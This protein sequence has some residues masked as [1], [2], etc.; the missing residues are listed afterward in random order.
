MANIWLIEGSQVV[1]RMVEIAL[2][3]L[4][5][6]L[7]FA[8]HVSELIND[9]TPSPHLIICA[10][11]VLDTQN[12]SQ[13]NTYLS[14]IE[15][16]AQQGYRCP[17]VVLQNQNTS[18]IQPC[19][20]ADGLPLVASVRKPF[21][22]FTLLKVTCNAMAWRI[23]HEEVYS[24]PSRV[25][26]LAKPRDSVMAEPLAP[27]VMAEPPA[28]PVM[29]EPPA[30]P[31]M[32]EPPAPPVMA[33]PPAPPM[34]AEPP[35]PPVMAE[36]PAP[37]VMAEPPAPPMMAESSASAVS[38]DAITSSL[39]E[40]ATTP[41]P[42]VQVEAPPVLNVESSS[43]V[44]QSELTNL[45][46]QPQSDHESK[47][48]ITSDSGVEEEQEIAQ[49]PSADDSFQFD[50][51]NSKK[52]TEYESKQSSTPSS[53]PLPHELQD[54]WLDESGATVNMAALPSDEVEMDS[55]T[56]A[57]E[58]SSVQ[59][60]KFV[61]TESLTPND[62]KVSESLSSINASDNLESRWLHELKASVEAVSDQALEVVQKAIQ[63]SQSIQGQ[64]QATLS[65]HEIR[66]L[67]ERVAWE[68]VPSLA[69]VE[70][71]ERIQQITS[72]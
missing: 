13:T 44:P 23:P 35:A 53:T 58:Y 64:S 39:M 68:V 38:S 30:P 2:D 41:P 22:T 63:T 62:S 48:S 24:A 19:S 40:D 31:V 25:I 18:E 67:I 27:S 59:E 21:K 50:F 61:V 65:N 55:P 47:T 5:A 28:P 3:G 36:P 71:R 10:E 17:V 43:S 42:E 69:S 51:D 11:Y 54:D 4:P 14:Q 8:Q 6:K 32:A 52:S 56:Q 29:A 16:L 7:S 70:L 20:L 1:R 60:R 66:V 72:K 49:P 12:T 34:M 45:S 57:E 33:E 26:P 15:Y 46:P 9:D 37:P